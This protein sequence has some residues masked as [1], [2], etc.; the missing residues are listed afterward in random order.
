MCLFD[1]QLRTLFMEHVWPVLKNAHSSHVIWT[2]RFQTLLGM[3]GTLIVVLIDVLHN[4][5]GLLSAFTSN[6]ALLAEANIG[7]GVLY[8]VMR[9]YKAD[10]F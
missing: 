7:I 8:E 4:N 10:D 2:A 5:L 9:R 6:Q 3:L 1:F